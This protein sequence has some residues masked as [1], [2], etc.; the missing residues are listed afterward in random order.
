VDCSL[1]VGFGCLVKR[2]EIFIN[3]L[4]NCTKFREEFEFKVRYGFPLANSFWKKKRKEKKTTQNEK[5][6]GKTNK[7]KKKRKVK[8]KG[9]KC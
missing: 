4:S 9:R 7:K 8:K 2:C 5:Q 1:L 3:P 6:N